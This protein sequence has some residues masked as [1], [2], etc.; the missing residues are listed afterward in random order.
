MRE[1]LRSIDQKVREAAAPNRLEWTSA[2]SSMNRR[3]V[4]HEP[5]RPYHQK[6]ESSVRPTPA[7][8]NGIRVYE[9]PS[10]GAQQQTV[11]VQAASFALPCYIA[12]S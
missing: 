8:W 6:R 12:C 7:P 10:E 5:T 4:R 3:A 11:T 9:R 2:S 1:F